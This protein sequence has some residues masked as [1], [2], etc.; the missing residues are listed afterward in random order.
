MS[1]GTGGM[2]CRQ[3][4]WIVSAIVGVVAMFG[5][6]GSGGWAV[7]PAVVAGIVMF[8]LAGLIL[9]Y[10]FCG[11]ASAPV[12]SEPAAPVATAAPKPAA[13][14][15][16][17]REPAPE[18]AV[19]PTPAMGDPVAPAP[20]A[21]A[22]Q[23]APEPAPVLIKPSA[24]LP[25]QD[26]LAAAKGDWKYVA[27]AKEAAPKPKA[28]PQAQVKPSAPLKGQ[29]ELAAAKG[30]WK[31]QPE[32]AAATKPAGLAAPRGGTADNLRVIEGVGAKLE[33]LLNSHGIWHYDQI[34]GWSDAD[35]AWM[36]A[37]LPRF[38][39]RVTRDKW[40]AQAKLIGE[41]GVEEF[42]VRAKTNDY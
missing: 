33:E 29:E 4:C 10:F 37:N 25:G 34:A 26:E 18:P 2:G 11:E 36:D 6:A 14:A 8:A 12:M 32:P 31:Y 20:V 3:L 41:V 28:K 9:T 27:P 35:V 22:V 17:A 23:R 7:L 19:A 40:V 5:L 30:D 21:E 13:A 38:K 15:P 24:A 1:N 39:G 16:A 42:L